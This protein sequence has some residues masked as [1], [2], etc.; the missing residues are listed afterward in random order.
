MRLLPSYLKSILPAAQLFAC[1][2]DEAQSDIDEDT[3]I[4]DSF[5]ILFAVDGNLY[6]VFGRYDK[7]VVT[8]AT[9]HTSR[10]KARLG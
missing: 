10:P 1:S 4:L 3:R 9:L 6:A 8:Q 5:E 2:L 7:D